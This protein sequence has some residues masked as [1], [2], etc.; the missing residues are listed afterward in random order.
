MKKQKN[1][2]FYFRIESLSS[3]TT[4]SCNYCTLHLPDR[5]TV[6]FLVDC[7]YFQDDSDPELNESFLFNPAKIAFAVATHNHLD[8]TGRFPILYAQGYEGKIY[9]SEYTTEFLKKN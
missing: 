6:E 4:G 9:A 2:N 8:H 7:G 3:V 1:K 5:R